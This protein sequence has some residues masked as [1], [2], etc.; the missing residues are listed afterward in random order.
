MFAKEGTGFVLALCHV[1]ISQ[2]SDADPP[3]LPNRLCYNNKLACFCPL[4]QRK[5]CVQIQWAC[6]LMLP[7]C[8]GQPKTETGKQI[9]S[10]TLPSLKIHFGLLSLD[11]HS[12]LVVMTV[13]LDRWVWN[14]FPIK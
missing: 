12:Y 9:F 4:L 11:P 8:P 1:Q 3:N 7:P 10:V 13:V 14:F 2:S 5:A 6:T